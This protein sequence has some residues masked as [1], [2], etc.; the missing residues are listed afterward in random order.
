MLPPPYSEQLMMNEIPNDEAERAALYQEA[1][2]LGIPI[3]KR[4][5]TEAIREHIARNKVAK[6]QAME[7]IKAQEALRAAEKA[8]EVTVRIT[9]L[10]HQKI[11]RGVH[12]PGKGDL[13]FSWKETTVLERPI[14][15]A[16]EAKGFVEIDEAA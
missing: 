2:S 3:D 16:L 8:P 13:T 7:I 9:K 11:S 5:G 1:A 10:G 6:A 14:A 15:E 12:I 4:R